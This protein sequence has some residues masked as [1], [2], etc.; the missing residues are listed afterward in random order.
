M[1]ADLS[2]HHEER[3]GYESQLESRIA[4]F[5]LAFR[6]QA[7]AP[8]VMDI[9]DETSATRRLYGLEDEITEG[10]G[11]QCLLARR[12]CEH[13][14]RFVQCNSNGWDH[15]LK[16]KENMIKKCNQVDRPIAGSVSYTHLTLP[17]ILRV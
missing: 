12:F 9:S 17:T 2:R 7:V 8:R 14:V 6:M 16:L 13:G 11:R 3:V 15:H 10:F 1:L 4:T 5:E